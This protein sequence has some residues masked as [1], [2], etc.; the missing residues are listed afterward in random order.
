M[1]DRIHSVTVALTKNIRIDDAQPI[2]DAI[3]MIKGV[4]NVAPNIAD[5]SD[6]VIRQRVESEIRSRILASFQGEELC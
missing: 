1:T 6:W 3:G 4:L 5:S 2:L